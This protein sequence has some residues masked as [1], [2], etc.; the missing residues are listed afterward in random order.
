M[1]CSL[2][3]NFI[4]FWEGQDVQNKALQQ[5]VKTGHLFSAIKM[6]CDSEKSYA[7]QIEIITSRQEL[8]TSLNFRMHLCTL[9]NHILFFQTTVVLQELAKHSSCAD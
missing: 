3:H 5:M 8:S 7:I 4:L 9:L 2:F 1:G 6:G